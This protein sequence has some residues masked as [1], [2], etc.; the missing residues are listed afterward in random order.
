MPRLKRTPTGGDGR[1]SGKLQADKLNPR[2]KPSPLPGQLVDRFGHAH[3]E[4]IF[5]NWSPAVIKAL[6]I[7][8]VDG[9]GRR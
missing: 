2:N 8:R 1:G 6:G 9:R 3:S 4:A 7:R 5:R